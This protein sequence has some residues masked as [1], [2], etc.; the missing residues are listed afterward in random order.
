MKKWTSLFLVLTM[1]STNVFAS[2]A[3]L[4]TADQIQSSDLTKLFSFPAATDTLVGRASTDTFTNK[5]ISG[6][7]NTL[8][9]IPLGSVTGTLA[10]GS[11]GTGAT[12]LTL[13]GMLF[14]NGTSAVGVTAAGSQYQVFQAG[15]SGVP[16]VGALQ[17][18][19]AA[20]TAG[21]LPT[22]RGGLGIDA[23]ASTGIM[24]I[25]SGVTTFA[26]VDLASADISGNLSVGHLNSATGASGTTFWRGDGT[27]ATP[28]AA[29]PALNGGSGA[30]Q[31]VTA[32]GGIVLA[33][34]TYVNFAWIVSNG[35]AVTVTA[36]PSITAG[37]IDGEI[38]HIVGTS[39]TN[40]VVLQDNAGL[41]GSNLQLNGNIALKLYSVITLH[42]NAALSF[43]VEE[44]R[45]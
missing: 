12:T 39:D 15:A 4:L 1:L 34:Q 28:A 25:A 7:T 31:T 21:V 44:S 3:R 13:N 6:A 9:N 27:W 16:T 36:T 8:T 43:W 20:A 38:L 10:V 45:R 33:G 22:S 18:S 2:T 32:A 29:S 23:S 35:G 11:G 30:P 5:S 42:W 24:H 41:S 37:T 40:Y 17:L 26:P 14:G 19:Q